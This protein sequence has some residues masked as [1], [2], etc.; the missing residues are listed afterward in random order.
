MLFEKE[1]PEPV[2]V[3]MH[4]HSPSEMHENVTN[5]VVGW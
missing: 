5:A 2:H 4:L 3:V 1:G